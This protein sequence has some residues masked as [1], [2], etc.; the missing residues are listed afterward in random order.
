MPVQ[1]QGPDGQTYQFP[2]GTD[3]AGAVAYFKKK[4]IGAKAA[5]K[6]S[7]IDQITEIRPHQ[8]DTPLHAVED[9]FGNIGAGGLSVLLHPVD[10]VK[11]VGRFL[12][13]PFTPGHP[14]ATKM[15]DDL[16]SRPLE[17]AEGMIGQGAVM[18]GIG[19][20]V[21]AA[22]KALPEAGG[23]VGRFI[24]KTGPKETA[25]L[26]KDTKAANEAA[27]VKAGE[28]T[29]RDQA[30]HAEDVG[31]IQ[32]K[33]GMDLRKHFDKTKDA[34][35]ANEAAE[36]KVSRK[37]AI[38]RGVERLDTEVRGDLEKVEK[39]VNK[40]ANRRYNELR[41]AL[42]DEPADPYQQ[43]D[44]QGSP[45]GEPVTLTEHLYDVANEPLRGTETET[46]IIKS[47]GKRTQEGDV[48]LSY[49]DL[50]G[51]REEIGRELRKGT[52]P[53]DVY[54]SYKNLMREIDDAMGRIAERKG[55]KPQQDA[56]RAFYRQYAETF[57]DRDAVARK[58]LDSKERGGVAKAYQ[59]K[60]QSGIESVARFDTGAAQRLNNLRGY[61]AE[62]KALPAKPGK[63]ASIPKL[64]PKP[65]IP[66][67]PAPV[68]PELKT[69]GPEDIR[70][71]KLTSLQEKGIPGV[72]KVGN[73]VVNYGLGLHALWDAFS[74]RF[75]DLPR[76]IGLGAA[77]Y[78][79]TEMFA[80]LLAKP[81]IQEMLT[82]PTAED[83]A[84]IPPELRGNLGPMLE[85]AKARGI[86]VD[87]RLYA[88]AAGSPDRKRVAAA[89]PP[90]R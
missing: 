79:A 20:G 15:V 76:D 55:M 27:T 41:A 11:G 29:A 31:K 62:A 77:G 88:V 43:V 52:L 71:K 80:R 63:L 81:E 84:Q 89:L 24:S 32:Q 60:D 13:D 3:K 51:Y 73:R 4:G 10:T 33:R 16:A 61:Q 2:D 54:T 40:E 30:K 56:A 66:E 75:Q 46:S 68:Q 90:P 83:L 59:G 7:F 34:K 36:G 86:K 49:N 12:A 22:A 50:Q 47:L 5:P 8:S 6:K 48:S 42:K 78:A 25:E 82:R 9:V 39:N 23:K 72:R 38:G 69:L 85:A 64:G 37:E 70:A 21:G 17:T 26:V 67:S 14:V 44:E 45:V 28:Q 1:V 74:G 19:E 35:A 58:A 53:P 57:L 18:G 65:N 87:P